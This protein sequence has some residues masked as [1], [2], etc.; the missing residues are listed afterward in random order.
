[1][2]MLSRLYR[3]RRRCVAISV[4]TTQTLEAQ[5]ATDRLIDQATTLAAEWTSVDD[6]L[7]DYIRKRVDYGTVAFDLARHLAESPQLPVRAQIVFP[8]MASGV[9][10]AEAV[11]EAVAVLTAETGLTFKHQFTLRELVFEVI[12]YK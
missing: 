2:G 9:P 5:A 12:S 7:R 4:M 11:A 3:R 10:T 8:L 6:V 1:M